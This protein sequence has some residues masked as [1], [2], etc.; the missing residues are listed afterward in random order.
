MAK[1]KIPQ[2]KKV[3]RNWFVLDGEGKIV[4]GLSFDTGNGYYF[5]SGWRREAEVKQKKKT[6]K[7]YQFGRDYDEAI[8]LFKQ[9]VAKD[10]VY[11]DIPYDSIV[12]SGKSIASPEDAPEGSEVIEEINEDGHLEGFAVSR[13]MDDDEIW[14][15]A[16]KLI[17]Q[18]IRE[19]SKKLGFPALIEIEDKLLKYKDVPKLTVTNILDFY[20]KYNKSQKKE[21]RMVRLAVNEFIKYIKDEDISNIDKFDVISF[22]EYL[23]SDDNSSNF[24]NKRIER[25]ITCFKYYNKN[26]EK[27]LLVDNQHKSEIAIVIQLIKEHTTKAEEQIND[28]PKSFEI[29]TLKKI[30]KHI[31]DDKE[32]TL[33]NLLALNC[34]FYA[35]DIEGLKKNMIR[36]K[37]GITYI[38]Y[39]RDKTQRTSPR[40]IILFDKTVKLLKEYIGLNPNNTEY[41]FLN[42][43]GTNLKTGTIQRKFKKLKDN[44]KHSDG[45]TIDFK[46]YRDTV[47]STLVYQVKNTDLL[48]ITIGHDFSG[49]KNVYWKYVETKIDEVKSVPEILYKKFKR[50]ID[51]L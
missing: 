17:L 42:S 14:R 31:K 51:I 13:Q 20:W 19:A 30:F 43:A 33:I 38:S 45:S 25:V 21:K 50:V 37:D 46:N 44:I 15:R 10:K 26:Y 12:E 49:K 41:I 35:I 18:D 9:W 22:N 40:I 5:Y 28:T 1:S 39:P 24:I 47:T 3:G 16:R 11:S 23:S 48:T 32:F 6:R 2:R 8:Y 4:E 7:D 27:K 34:G 36:E 29:N